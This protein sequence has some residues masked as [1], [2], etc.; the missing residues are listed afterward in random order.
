MTPSIVRGSLLQRGFEI[1]H[2]PDNHK[3]NECGYHCLADII[4]EIKNMGY[5]RFI[6]DNGLTK[7]SP[8]EDLVLENHF[9]KYG[10]NLILV[11]CIYC[12]ENKKTTRTIGHALHKPNKASDKFAIVM[13]EGHILNGAPPENGTYD[14]I[15]TTMT[16]YKE[17]LFSLKYIIKNITLHSDI[18]KSKYFESTATV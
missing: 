2:N 5:E 10:Y 15:S 8:I 4:P 13:F 11:S 9:N 18:I 6:N 3:N 7:G 17:V 12:I 14:I 1:L 16:S